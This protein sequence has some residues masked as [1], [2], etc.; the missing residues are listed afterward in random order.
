MLTIRRI[1]VPIDE[2]Q[3]SD[4]VLDAALTIAER[5]GARVR[6]LFVRDEPG[7]LPDDEE[8][9]AT[10]VAGLLEMVR[11]RLGAGP[12]VDPKRIEA[13]LRTGAADEAIAAILEEGEVDLVVMGTHGRHGLADQLLGSTTERVIQA[14]KVPVLVIREQDDAER[15]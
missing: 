13:V 5:F 7:P 8:E 6:V 9:V 15:S 3:L 2:T 14:A 10:T 1:L 4:R 12:S 11:G